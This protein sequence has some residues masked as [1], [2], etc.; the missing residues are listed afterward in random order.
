MSSGKQTE[1]FNNDLYHF[2]IVDDDD[3]DN[4]QEKEEG[5]MN[6]LPDNCQPQINKRPY[7]QN[8]NEQQ[9]KRHCSSISDDNFDNT[10][11]YQKK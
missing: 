7:Q 11:H 3:D 1:A 2:K 5:E 4:D 10:D 9:S 6:Y 8:A